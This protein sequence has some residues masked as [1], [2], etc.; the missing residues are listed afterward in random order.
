VLFAHLSL[1]DY[2]Y[3]KGRWPHLIPFQPI[4]TILCLVY[5]VFP[6]GL[7]VAAARSWSTCV[8]VSRCAC[9][10][11]CHDQSLWTIDSC[12]WP[13]RRMARNCKAVLPNCVDRVIRPISLVLRL[14]TLV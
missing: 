4:Y 13:T 2:C 6:T 12:I 8:S 10:P 11:A 7:L 3:D 9:L 14:I 5:A 1:I